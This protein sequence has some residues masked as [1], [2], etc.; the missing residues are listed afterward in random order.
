MAEDPPLLPM[1]VLYVKCFL[2]E[3]NQKQYLK[4]T[5]NAW[6]EISFTSL[7]Y[8]RKLIVQIAAHRLDCKQ[9]LF[10]QSSLSSAGLERANWPRFPR[11]HDHP[12]RLSLASLDFLAR[13]FLARV[14]ILRDCS[15]ST[16]RSYFNYH[17]HLGVYPVQFPLGKHLLIA[18]PII[19]YPGLQKYQKYCPA[20]WFWLW[21]TTAELFGLPG[22]P[23]LGKTRKQ[24]RQL[25]WFW[26]S[27]NF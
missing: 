16:H 2:T 27:T 17:S 15:Q 22:S 13:A 5:R 25:N 23:Q 14:T 1:T 11:S 8:R 21:I 19:V 9:S 4:L 12:K 26:S 20:Q 24:P 3:F 10:S 7:T 6:T 18:G